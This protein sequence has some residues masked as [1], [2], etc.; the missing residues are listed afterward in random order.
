MWVCLPRCLPLVQFA[1]S[2]FIGSLSDRYGRRAI[3]LASAFGQSV[4]FAMMALAS[5]LE[6]LF[7]ARI[8][9]GISAGSLPA[10]NAYIADVVPDQH[11]AASYRVGI[12]CQFCGLPARSGAG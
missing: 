4:N 9:A 11:R 2:P 12:R 5:N 6:S 7:F 8:V 1:V 3:I 10:V